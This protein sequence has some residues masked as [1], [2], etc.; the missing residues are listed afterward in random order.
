MFEHL[1]IALS[2]SVA[3]A[4]S[5]AASCRDRGNCVRFVRFTRRQELLRQ[6]GVVPRLSASAALPERGRSMPG[7][8]SRRA[9]DHY[10]AR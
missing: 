4:A 5:G 1:R 10:R 7:R 8:E 3:G 2:K 6:S 9:P